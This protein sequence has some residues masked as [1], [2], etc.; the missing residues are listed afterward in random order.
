MIKPLCT[1]L[2][3]IVIKKV[4]AKV[5]VKPKHGKAQE[6]V[7]YM[8]QILFV[9]SRMTAQI[10]VAKKLWD[11]VRDGEVVSFD[12]EI[13]LTK[14]YRF[15]SVAPK[16]HNDLLTTASPVTPEKKQ[17]PGVQG[18]MTIKHEEPAPPVTP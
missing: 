17:E 7:V 3:A 1:N 15:T 11:S 4:S 2:R 9:G 10:E 8:L 14:F 12:A 13:T 16:P 5:A 18:T 6:Q